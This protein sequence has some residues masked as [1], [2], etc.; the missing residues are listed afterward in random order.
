ME[1]LLHHDYLIQALS[2]TEGASVLEL[3]KAGR[4]KGWLASTT[5]QAL[6]QG[7]KKEERNKIKPL[8]THLSV[9]T[10]TPRDLE[11][12]LQGND[13]EEN[14]ALTL[15]RSCGFDAVVSTMPEKFSNSEGLVLTADQV[16]SKIDGPVDSVNEV[17]LLDISASYHE[18]LN[19][20]E[21]EIA[22]T[23]RTGQFILGSKV[24]QLEEKI[25]EYDF[26]GKIVFSTF[27][28][29]KGLEREVVFVFSFDESYYKFYGL[30]CS[31]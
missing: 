17:K 19:D 6:W 7:L 23:T 12:A 16:Q 21:M 22:D 14:L 18:I 8:L 1:I 30:D 10:P 24:V 20:V 25:S 2:S 15:S 5:I 13:F 11:D 26:K 9:V 3:C 31:K 28:Q 27:H 4:C 29:V